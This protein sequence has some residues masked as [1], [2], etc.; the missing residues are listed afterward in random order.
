MQAWLTGFHA[1]SLVISKVNVCFLGDLVSFAEF[2][3]QLI[4]SFS[5][6]LAL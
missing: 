6:V 1:L 5:T 3:Q 4:N 2:N